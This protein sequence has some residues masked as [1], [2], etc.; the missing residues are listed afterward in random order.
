MK[1]TQKEQNESVPSATA[2]FQDGMDAFLFSKIL[3]KT[4]DVPKKYSARAEKWLEG[5]DYAKDVH[6]NPLN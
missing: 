1:K 5:W 6:K 4:R 3:G 2:A